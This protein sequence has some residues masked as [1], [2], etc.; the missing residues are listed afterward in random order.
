MAKSTTVSVRLKPEVGE[1]LAALAREMKYSRARAASEAI[2]AYVELKAWQV[3][4]IEDA[5]KEDGSGAAGLPHQE[6]VAWLES[7]GIDHEFP[8]PEPKKP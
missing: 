7:W 1:K 3:A 6:V 2:E 4:H 5:L 8:R